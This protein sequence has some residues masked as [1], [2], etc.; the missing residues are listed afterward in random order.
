MPTH[1]GYKRVDADWYLEPPSVV[2]ALLDVEPFPGLTLDP[3]C[4]G[5]NI[6]KVFQGRGLSCLGAD[7]HDR[8]YGVPGISI[9]DQHQMIDNI[10]TNPP[11]G[12]IEPYIRHA[13]TI[14]RRK[15]AVLASLN[16][17]ESRRRAPLFKETPFARVW[18]SSARISMP[19]GGTD[20]PAR[21]GSVAF[22]WFVWEHG[23]RHMPT[24]GW[25]S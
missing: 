19:P 18:V 13:L 10:V 16:L 3:S 25:L 21:N 7:L 20:I 6:P 12:I 9:F 15:V 4:G 22:G 14:T 5:G 23:Y 1:S 17:L 2:H 11:F 24:I 8:G